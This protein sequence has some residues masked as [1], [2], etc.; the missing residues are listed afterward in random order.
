MGKNKQTELYE[1][2]S[3]VC[4]MLPRC[5]KVVDTWDFQGK[6]S[7]ILENVGIG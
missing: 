4:L 5:N 6:L 7:F 1:E 2:K 3:A